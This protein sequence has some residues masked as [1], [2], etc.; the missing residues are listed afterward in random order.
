M[1]KS[2]SDKGSIKHIEG[3]DE[4]VHDIDDGVDRHLAVKYPESLVGLSEAEL[5]AVDRKATRKI[6]ILLMPTL[7]AL[8]VLNYLVRHHASKLTAGSAER[9]DSQDRRPHSRSEHEREPVRDLRCCSVC[10]L[11]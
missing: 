9:L 8:Y 5:A 7:M 4:T 1:S 10:R 3:V 6:D 11:Q 2:D